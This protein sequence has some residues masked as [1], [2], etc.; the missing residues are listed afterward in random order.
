MY[1]MIVTVIGIFLAGLVAL[2]T[3]YIGG[4]TFLDG[5]P[6]AEAARY[7]NEGQQVAAAIRLFQTDNHGELPKH[8]ET[9]LQGHYLKDMPQSGAN[10]DIA[11]N[12]IVKGIANSDTCEA[13]NK[14]S[15]W[16]NP[17]FSEG[18]E[19]PKKHEPITCDDPSLGD[20][21]YFCCVVNAADSAEG[22][23]E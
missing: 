9:D 17:Y 20:K 3:M 18:Q 16:V 11:T 5:K 14:K 7:I 19:S 1:T 21:V 8:L 13:V 22:T 4:G 23:A 15:G 2:A 12:A 6:Q 10:W